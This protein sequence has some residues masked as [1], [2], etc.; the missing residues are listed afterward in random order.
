MNNFEYIKALTD[1]DDSYISEAAEASHTAK[2]SHRRKVILLVAAATMALMLVACGV[3]N[4]LAASSEVYVSRHTSSTVNDRIDA[5]EPL[6]YDNDHVSAVAQEY[7]IAKEDIVVK[8]YNEYLSHGYYFDE[9]FI[10]TK[11][12]AVARIVTDAKN[13]TFDV[14]FIGFFHNEKKDEFKAVSQKTTAQGGTIEIVMNAEDGWECFG[15]FLGRSHPEAALNTFSGS[16][17]M[18]NID[19][20]AILFINDYYD[21]MIVQ[22]SNAIHLKEKSEVA[23]VWDYYNTHIYEDT[24][25]PTES[26]NPIDRIEQVASKYG[27][28]GIS[29]GETFY[30]KRIL[31]SEKFIEVGYAY[32]KDGLIAFVNNNIDTEDLVDGSINSKNVLV[33]VRGV[34]YSAEKDQYRVVSYEVIADGKG[35]L[36]MVPKDG[37]E[38]IGV[39]IYR[40]MPESE[41]YELTSVEHFTPV[42]GDETDS[43]KFFEKVKREVELNIITNQSAYINSRSKQYRT[44]RT[45]SSSTNELTESTDIMFSET[46]TASEVTVRVDGEDED[47]FYWILDYY[48]KKERLAQITKEYLDEKFSIEPPVYDPDFDYEKHYDEQSWSRLSYDYEKEAEETPYYYENGF[49]HM[50]NKAVVFNITNNNDVEFKTLV[51]GIFYNSE[52]DECITEEQYVEIYGGSIITMT[53][54]DGWEFESIIVTIYAHGDDKPI[55]KTSGISGKELL[56][57]YNEIVEKH[58]SDDF[59]KEFLAR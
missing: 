27:M 59:R 11:E 51:T 56:Q 40:S 57:I 9:V 54:Q 26:D 25:A 17:A 50:D 6:Q 22:N 4:V 53:A 14:E 29:N 28:E 16:S 5:L 55:T 45:V 18:D 20:R 7:G 44:G 12:T 52:T 34:F 35:I 41:Q 43:Q 38:C 31:T 48:D 2:F 39:S 30:D 10:V 1:I 46:K 33:R 58:K 49:V 21:K 32:D 13:F 3:Y 23:T 8:H 24:F 47:M 15:G 37:W 19:S 42:E 36:R